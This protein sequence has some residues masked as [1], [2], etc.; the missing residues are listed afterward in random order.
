MRAAKAFGVLAIVSCS[1]VSACNSSAPTR[2]DYA[3]EWSGT[4]SHGVPITFTISSDEHVTSIS[5]GH[6]FNG[7]SGSQTFSNLDL[8][9]AT[10]IT[11]PQGPCPAQLSTYRAFYYSDGIP[12]FDDRPTTFVYGHFPTMT[13]ASGAVGFRN[14]PGCGTVYAMWTA[15]RR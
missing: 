10:N 1:L 6:D 14:Y 7:C 9:I 12:T 15:S 2:L 13:L 5:V 4:T 8:P 11:C 3:G